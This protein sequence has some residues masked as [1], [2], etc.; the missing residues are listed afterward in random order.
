MSERQSIPIVTTPGELEALLQDGYKGV[1]NVNLNAD[2]VQAMLAK[3]SINRPIKQESVKMYAQ[4]FATRGYE[5]L[6]MMC[7]TDSGVLLDGQHRLTALSMLHKRGVNV[8]AWQ[9]VNIGVSVD[10][11]ADIDNGVARSLRD[12]LYLTGKITNKQ[13]ISAVRLYA[14]IT[15]P[16]SRVKFSAA[17]LA[18]IYDDDFS[19]V[20]E[21]GDFGY[22][23]MTGDCCGRGMRPA[24]FVVTCFRLLQIKYGTDAIRRVYNHFYSGTDLKDPMVY[25]RNYL[26]THKGEYRIYSCNS[27]M[28]RKL[29]GTLFGAAKKL[30]NDEPWGGYI[31]PTTIDLTINGNDF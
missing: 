21:L 5:S 24:P 20:L 2:V 19:Q 27:P 18:K 4:S 6:S 9:F 28:T 29:M 26:V 3:N 22:M 31:R 10:R 25:F 23:P 7:I 14:I 30:L 12:G 15:S 16:T 13:M 1:A 17:E 11:M 8:T